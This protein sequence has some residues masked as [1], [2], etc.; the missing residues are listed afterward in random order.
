MPA[1]VARASV[2]FSSIN[3]PV[4]GVLQVFEVAPAFDGHQS[5]F[6]E[7]YFAVAN[8]ELDELLII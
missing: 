2:F 8:E 3:C 6:V 4:A 7:P 5:H 1:S